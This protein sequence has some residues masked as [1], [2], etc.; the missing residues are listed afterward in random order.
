MGQPSRSWR[1]LG[2]GQQF[3]VDG[4]HPKT[5]RPY[6]WD[7]HPFEI[8]A[9]NLTIIDDAKI[10]QFVTRIEFLTD[11][12]GYELK[13]RTEAAV[14][15]L[16]SPELLKGDPALIKEAL[17]F[18][19]NP[20][21]YDEWI[22]MCGAVKFALGC[23]ESH[24]GIYE[25]WC[26]LDPRNTRDDAKEKWDSMRK[27]LSGADYVFHKAQEAGWGGWLKSQFGPVPEATSEDQ[28]LR[29]E[30]F[31][32]LYA[33][34]PEPVPELVTGLVEKG[35]ATFLSGAGGSN[36]SRLAIQM[37]L[38]ID[39]G[40]PVLGHGTMQARFVY[41][42]SEDDRAEVQRR[43]HAI[44]SR[45]GLS[46]E[47]G[48]IYIDRRGKN[49]A[50]AIVKPEKV[51]RTSF[52][53][54][55]RRQLLAIPGHKFV[56]FDSCYDFVRFAEG[57]KIDEGA[58]NAFCKNVLDDLCVETD[59]T[60]LVLWHPSQAGEDRG[61]ASGWSVAWRNAPRGRLSLTRSDKGNSYTLKVEKRSHA[62]DGA[63][64]VLYWSDGA[65][66]VPEAFEQQE[67]RDRFYEA[68]VVFATECAGKGT[69]I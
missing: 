27:P 29:V 33:E 21:D 49:S 31:A 7:R 62:P 63:K 51:T 23:D 57:G 55:L 17:A 9:A 54:D 10:E 1:S 65:L 5:G 43:V 6:T 13:A 68:C 59:L 60:V 37:G 11:A 25:E 19:G 22:A 24:Y 41:V 44:G 50:L 53:D 20:F 61:D 67:R 42:S 32:D 45:L 28:G 35:I 64:E 58:V 47:L 56:A 8:G 26:L 36:K 12:F 18:L 34:P 52:C 15:E 30:T 14:G 16:H 48:A 38:C 2:E 39:E 3:V 4:I 66:V 40:A 69:P 46:K